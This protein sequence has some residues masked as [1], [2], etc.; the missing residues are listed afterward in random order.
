MSV[1]WSVARQTFVQCL[2]SRAV[3]VTLVLL[4]I[5]L[6]VMP[7][8]LEGDNTLAGRV[9]TFLSYSAAAASFTLSALTVFFSVILI[10][11]DVRTKRIFTLA[12][13]PVARWEFVIGRWVGMAMLN[14]VL[15]VAAGG[16][17][18]LLSQ[19][20]RSGAMGQAISPADRSAVETEVFTARTR[21]GPVVTIDF[22]QLTQDRLDTMADQ[23]SLEP[24]LAMY[25][26]RFDTE[27]EAMAALYEEIYK[28]ISL[29]AQ[30]IGTGMEEFFYWRFE[31]IDLHG[32]SLTRDGTVVIR[33]EDRFRVHASSDVLSR[34][35]YGG[36]LR[37]NGVDAYVTKLEDDYVDI[38]L[39]TDTED[40]SGI[41]SVKKGDTVTLTADPTIQLTHKAASAM[42]PP[43]GLLRCQWRVGNPETQY[44][45]RITRNDAVRKP[46]T[47]TLPGR[48]VGRAVSRDRWVKWRT[49]ELMRDE[50][51]SQSD[52]TEKAEADPLPTLEKAPPSCV[53]WATDAIYL[54][55]PHAVTGDRTSVVILNEDVSILF[56]VSS[57][58]SNIIRGLLLIH[59]QLMYLSALGLVAGTFLSFP[60]GVLA[61]FSVLPFSLGRAYLL[62]GLSMR[63]HLPWSDFWVQV[64]QESSGFWWM[65]WSWLVWVFGAI[66]QGTIK[67]MV[68]LMPNLE[69][70]EAGAFWVDGMSISWGVL[71]RSAGMTVG[72]HTGLLLLLACWIY[73][74]RELARVQV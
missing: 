17:I 23:G 72:I 73:T 58:E 31:G 66:T 65:I 33:H 18:Y 49:R 24:S 5:L 70:S 36:P 21:V 16:G 1:I 59:F 26:A 64:S 63:D 53:V 74:R 39:F 50:G 13:K 41:R 14:G 42:Y 35:V 40:A 8:Q 47:V 52:A 37:I 2:R 68:Q 11:E 22:D 48:V 54:N 69:A 57:F 30:S 25:E 27:D 6:V 32:E 71:G 10:S 44:L 43:D 4:A 55:L 38:K 7:F 34:L 19:Q 60:V 9:R 67:G 62:E 51:M 61:T 20:L 46:A 28:Q 3:T 12:V 29:D 45:Y 56:K 15:L